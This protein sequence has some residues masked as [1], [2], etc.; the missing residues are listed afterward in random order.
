MVGSPTTTLPRS[1]SV[2]NFHVDRNSD[3]KSACSD[4]PRRRS[5]STISNRN[6]DRHGIWSS[7]TA[8]LCM[9]QYRDTTR[10]S[11]RD[12]IAQT[13][14]VRA[15]PNS[16]AAWGSEPTG[17]PKTDVAAR[18]LPQRQD[19]GQEAI[20]NGAAVDGAGKE[21]GDHDS[22][23]RSPTPPDVGQTVVF[24]AS[25]A[26]ELL[27]SFVQNPAS[28]SPQAAPSAPE[29]LPEQQV[30]KRSSKLA[31]QNPTF[32]G[33]AETAQNTEAPPEPKRRH[34]R[35]LSDLSVK[36]P[37]LERPQQSLPLPEQQVTKRSSK[38]AVQNPP[39]TG[40]AETGKNAEA[41]PK[42]RNSKIFSDLSVKSPTI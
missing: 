27:A 26:K 4:M 22:P 15:P 7:A 30:T 11:L 8:Q 31:V 6:K 19:G 37:D 13:P 25:F 20:G 41:V 32:T 39:F 35:L 17:S 33:A 34:S 29:P 5:V 36:S 2:T 28:H 16:Q 14:L 21:G 1:R 9:P 10:S 38:L 40:A 12:I 3:R 18:T 23:Q 24:N 42:R